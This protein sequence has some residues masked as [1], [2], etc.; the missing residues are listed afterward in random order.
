[1]DDIIADESF[2]KWKQS[3]SELAISERHLTIIYDCL[4]NLI[5]Q[6]KKNLRRKTK[7][8]LF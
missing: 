7:A 8:K 5:Q 3:L 6:Y 1:M 2:D 4:H